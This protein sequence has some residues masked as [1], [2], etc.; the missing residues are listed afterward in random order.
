MS[1]AA[2][3]T[4]PLLA[5]LAACASQPPAPPEPPP[6]PVPAQ[7]QDRGGVPRISLPPAQAPAEGQ[8]N[9]SAPYRFADSVELELTP[10]SAGAW[11]R[12]DEGTDRWRLDL[13]SP[14]ATSLNL[15]FDRFALPPGASL[16]LYDPSAPAQSL[17][18]SAADNKPHGQLWTPQIRGDTLRLDLRLPASAGRQVGLKLKTVNIAW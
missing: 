11:S 3:R 10:R 4:L 2:L 15:H 12:W 14:G 18:L 17:T 8:D 7:T 16:K 5:C 6:P 9:K 13:H 1:I